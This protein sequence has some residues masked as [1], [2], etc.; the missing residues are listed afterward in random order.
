MALLEVIHLTGDVERRDL[1]KRQ[2]MTIGSHSSCDLRIDEKGVERIHCRIS[3]NKDNWEALAAGETALELNGVEVQRAV[4]N[5]GDVLRFGTVDVKFHGGLTADDTPAESGGKESTGLKPTSEEAIATSKAAAADSRKAAKSPKSDEDL[6][7]S[8]EMLAMDSHGSSKSKKKKY[9]EDDI[10]EDDD[11]FEE[12]EEEESVVPPPKAAAKAPAKPTRKPAAEEASD[13]D[14]DDEEELEEQA[15][16]GPG[17]LTRLTSAIKTEPRRP[18]DDDPLRSPLVLGLLGGSILLVLAGLTFYFIAG[19]RIAE[20][21]FEAAK[22]LVTEG[23]FKA[24]IDALSEFVRDFP[25][26]PKLPEAE[27]LIGLA[28][29]DQKLAA[30]D[31]PG[32]I[33]AIRDFV[34]DNVDNENFESM[35]SE[36]ATRAG[37]AALGA[38]TLGGRSPATGR[39]LLATSREALTLFSSYSPKDSQPKEQIEKINETIRNS[40]NLIR[41]HELNTGITAKITAAL[42]AKKPME[43]LKLRRDLIAQ[44]AD[45]AKDKEIT[46]LLNKA[47]DLEKSLVVAET[48]NSPSEAADPESGLPGPR[49]VT[50]HARVRTDGV[51]VNEIAWVYGKDCLY[52]VDTVTGLPVWRRVVGSD[53]P[54]FPVEDDS[55]PSLICFDSDHNE[56]LRIH[57]KLGALIWRQPLGTRVTGKPLLLQGQIYM[58]TV[59]G[60]LLQVDLETGTLAARLTFSQP[61][62]GPGVIEGAPSSDG[63]AADSQLVVIGDQDVV[64]TLNRRPLECVAVSYLAQRSQSVVAPL[65]SMGPYLAYVENLS[66]DNSRLHLLKRDATKP[67]LFE[68]AS[69]P[70]AGMVVD[71]AVIRGRDLFVPSTVERISA[72]SVSDTPD[73]P[74]LTVGPTF[75]V[76]GAKGSPIYLTLG[77]ERQVWMSSSAL[78]KLQLTTDSIQADPNVVAI[79]ISSQPN[80]HVGNLLFNARRRSFSDGITLTQTERDSLTSEWQIQVGAK[81]LA[82]S[83]YNGETPSV[84][85]VNEGGATFRILGADLGKPGFQTESAQLLPVNGETT[86]PLLA[87]ALPDSQIAVACGT[88]EARVWVI[89]R[90]GQIEKQG[91]LPANPQA[92]PVPLGKRIVVPVEGRLHVARTGQADSVVQDFQFP[93]G[94]AAPVWKQV[95]AVDDKTLVGLTE[96]GQ[97]LQFRL[98]QNP[99]P[100]LAEVSRQALS[101]PATGKIEIH[102]AQFAVGTPDGD[103]QLIDGMKFNPIGRRTLASPSSGPSFVTDAGVLVEVDG[104][105]LLCLNADGELTD[106]W[107]IERPD[108]SL[109]GQPQMI[110]GQLVLAFEDGTVLNV[111]PDSGEIL[112][113]RLAAGHLDSGPIAIGNQWALI[114]SDGSLVSL[115]SE[116]AKP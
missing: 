8:L 28:A 75:Q 94:E 48:P 78:R 52:G 109:S 63:Q 30:S 21:E 23:K 1:Y 6:M 18:G 74:I 57:R 39:D 96:D 112:K 76:Q 55:K 25:G 29:I 97:L 2:P 90:L 115:T 111:N 113:T 53:P 95:L 69:G 114:T 59:D 45:Y 73:E 54:F 93:T 77:P 98:E 49:T 91:P 81:L 60:D 107:K 38:A 70:I 42:E 20:M 62:V 104:P 65:V 68:V 12:V 46:S 67:G 66:E 83:P 15:P 110:G 51:S 47:L 24:G 101:G 36:V 105:E 17:V 102:N 82:V 27:M 84:L 22:A 89:N 31:F 40:E 26:D 64:Y 13:D 10:F 79:G 4:L 11:D 72:F 33:K 3:W 71:E 41:K 9:K 99:R 35:K 5:S 14:D 92:A 32:G 37:A 43:A 87:G 50:F 85:A 58:T 86:L 80:Q 88:P 34:N 116:G 106:K 16:K 103:L 7:Q 56:L 19:R 61:V 44:Y 108:S 100:H